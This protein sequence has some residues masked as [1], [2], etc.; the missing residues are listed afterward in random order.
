M[1]SASYP[2]TWSGLLWTGEAPE[3]LAGSRAS[4]PLRIMSAQDAR[5]PEDDD[6]APSAALGAGSGPRSGKALHQSLARWEFIVLRP[7]I[8][9]GEP[10]RLAA[11]Q[12]TPPRRDGPL[13][14]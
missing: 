14:H 11:D 4:G 12:H 8:G 6:R 9:D 2:S 7:V 5:G 3:F 1:P 13:V 10:R